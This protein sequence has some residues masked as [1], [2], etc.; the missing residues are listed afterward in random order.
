VFF[1]LEQGVRAF[2]V[3]MG[4]CLQILVNNFYWAAATPRQ[5]GLLFGREEG[6][7]FVVELLLEFLV[8]DAGGGA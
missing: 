5:R 6:V 4:R 8:I 3:L 2:I 1:G 7:D